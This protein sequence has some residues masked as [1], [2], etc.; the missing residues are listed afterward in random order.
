M[1]LPVI[2]MK[3]RPRY[4][5][6]LRIVRGSTPIY[7]AAALSSKSSLGLVVEFIL[8]PDKVFKFA[9]VYKDAFANLVEG[10]TLSVVCP[11]RVWADIHGLLAF[12]EPEESEFT[13]VL[14]VMCLVFH[15]WFLTRHMATRKAPL[16]PG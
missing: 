2:R 5:R 15:W 10:Q 8:L 16:E 9:I 4:V 6:Q 11:Q 1:T 3:G 12:A 7:S 14:M 13:E